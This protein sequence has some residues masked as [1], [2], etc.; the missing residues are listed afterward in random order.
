MVRRSR[1]IVSGCLVGLAACFFAAPLWSRLVMDQSMVDASGTYFVHRT[2][3]KAVPYW[4]HPICIWE[5]RQFLK[6]GDIREC[7]VTVP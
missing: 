3:P 1:V 7:G 4:A 2:D 6:A 5:D